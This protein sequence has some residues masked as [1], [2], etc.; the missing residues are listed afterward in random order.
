MKKIAFFISILLFMGTMA[1]YA[2]TRLVTGRVTS[3]EDGQ[4]VPGVSI[5][6]QGTTLGTVTNIDGDYSLQVPEDAGNLTF[7]FVGMAAQT[8]EIGGRTTINIELEPE[9]IG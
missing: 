8:V 3:A 4:P 9:T 1:S 2:Q 6:V 7:S 5:V